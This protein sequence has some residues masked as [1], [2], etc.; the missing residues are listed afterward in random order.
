DLVVRLRPFAAPDLPASTPDALLAAS[1]F[2]DDLVPRLVAVFATATDTL[3]QLRDLLRRGKRPQLH[4]V[5]GWAPACGMT[6]DRSTRRQGHVHCND[7][8]A[9]LRSARDR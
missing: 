4:Q 7:D 1:S 8:R 2:A 6:I 9:F 3:S 5:S